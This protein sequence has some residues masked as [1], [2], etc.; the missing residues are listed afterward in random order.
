LVFN[1]VIALPIG[2][3]FV[4]CIMNKKFPFIAS[5]ICLVAVLILCALGVWQ[6]ERLQWKND[7][8][9]QLDQAFATENPAPFDEQQIKN[10]Q[11]GQ[12]LRGAA[13]GHLNMSKAVLFHGRIQDGQSVMSVV[14]PFIL[15]S[16]DIAFPVEVGCTA[17]PDI[18]KIKSFADQKIHA[19][20]VLRQPRWSFATPKNIPDKQEW[21]RMDSQDLSGSWKISNLENAYLTLE[22]SQEIDASLTACPIEKKLRNDHASYAFFWFAMAFILSIIWG[23]RFLRPYLQSA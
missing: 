3:E 17:H 11:K 8:Q 5:F 16:H 7:L 18:Q 22:N 23:I 19:I 20:G 14:A 21:W 4:N 13:D 10:L 6:I 1:I 15:S 12:V 2:N 9:A